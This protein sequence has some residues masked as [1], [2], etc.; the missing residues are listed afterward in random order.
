VCQDGVSR[1]NG[2]WANRKDT[3]TDFR[4]TNIPLRLDAAIRRRFES[5]CTFLFG[6]GSGRTWSV[7]LGDTN[8]TVVDNDFDK[9]GAITRRYQWFRY[10]GARR[11]HSWNPC[12]VANRPSSLYER[13]WLCKPCESIPTAP[14][15][16]NC[17]RTR[18]AGLY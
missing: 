17:R 1:A 15:V 14:S 5:A 4:A 6:S 2:R 9:L 7:H 11:K 13:E 16:T 10:Q 12:D 8:G 18:A 3:Y